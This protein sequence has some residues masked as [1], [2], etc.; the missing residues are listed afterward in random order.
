VEAPGLAGSMRRRRSFDPRD[1]DGLATLSLVRQDGVMRWLYQPAMRGPNR[2]RAR[3]D[4]TRAIGAEVVHTFDFKELKPNE[5]IKAFEDLDASLTPDQGLRRLEN[6]KLVP[7]TGV[8]DGPVLLFVHGTFSKCDM[9][10]DELIT[11]PEGQNFLAQ[12][13]SQTQYKAVLAF[14][15][16]TLSVSPWI[17][18]LDLEVA[19]ARVKGPIDVICH[20]RGGL[21]VGWW[22]RNSLRPVRKVVFVGSPLVGTGLASP[23]NLRGALDLLANVFKGLELAGGLASTVMPFMAVVTGVAKI[24]GGILQ[25]GA[26]T[27]LVDAG[28]ALVPGLVAQSQ[29]SNNAELIRLN[30]PPWISQPTLYAVRSNFEPSATGDPWWQFWKR[31]RNLGA[32]V[33]EA[34]AAMIFNGQNDLVVDTQ[35]MTLLCGNEIPVKQIRDFGTSRTVHHCNYFRQPETATFLQQALKP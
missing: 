20:S 12:A 23:A 17:N 7:F 5:V 2:G 19:L 34:G 25:L 14:D 22:L 15:H 27:P 18:A 28:I 10:V 6:G 21:V 8:V 24:V 30:R 16:P 26:R 9:F 13:S 3:R 1:Y 11:I 29:V 35:S 32:Q 33:A 4:A 31:F